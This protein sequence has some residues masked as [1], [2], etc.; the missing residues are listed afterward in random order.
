MRVKTGSEWES[1]GQASDRL[2][3]DKALYDM[4][5][6]RRVLHAG[7]ID[8][9]EH[10]K[11]AKAKLEGTKGLRITTSNAVTHPVDLAVCLSMA[12]NSLEYSKPEPASAGGQRDVHAARG[13][14]SWERGKR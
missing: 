8:L 3:A 10:I 6:E 7:D 12:A 2:I 14:S 13:K 1:F 11:H 5:K 4:I 9:A